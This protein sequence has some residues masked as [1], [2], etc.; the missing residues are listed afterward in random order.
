MSGMRLLILGKGNVGRREIEK[1]K[2]F[3]E[4]VLVAMPIGLIRQTVNGGA[5][6]GPIKNW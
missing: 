5:A 2:I 4:N 6:N 3:L 1:K